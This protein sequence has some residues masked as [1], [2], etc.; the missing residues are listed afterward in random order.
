MR[1][2]RAADD[3]LGRLGSVVG[4]LESEPAVVG[5]WGVD[6]RENVLWK[7]RRELEVAGRACCGESWEFEYDAPEREV[8]DVAVERPLLAAGSLSGPLYGLR[9]GLGAS[10]GASLATRLCAYELNTSGVENGGYIMFRLK[11]S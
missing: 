1:I 9:R 7:E 2:E 8:D 5:G 3:V 4:L 6:D 10:E 11:D